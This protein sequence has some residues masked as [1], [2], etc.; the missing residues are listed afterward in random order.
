MAAAGPGKR[1]YRDMNGAN[2][3]IGGENA[4]GHR[5]LA[6]ADVRRQSN[7]D[8]MNLSQKGPC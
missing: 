6:A 1:H 4:P 2:Q 3:F 8:G 5:N 7:V